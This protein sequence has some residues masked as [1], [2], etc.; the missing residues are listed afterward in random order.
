MVG[1]LTFAQQATNTDPKQSYVTV[2]TPKT[3]ES[4]GFEKYGDTKVNEFTGTTN[5]A[6]PIYTLKS[7]FLET[8]VTLAYNASGIRVNQEASWVG[9]GFDLIAG[10]RITV[11]TRGSVDFCGATYGLSSPTNLAAGMSQI[12][13]H[14]GNSGENAILNPATIV[15]IGP[16]FPDAYNTLAVSDMTQ[17][18]AGEPDIF[19]ANFMGHSTTYYID[20]ITGNLNF[21]GEQSN[22]NINYTLDNN[23]NIISWTIKDDDGITYN[24]NQ[25]ETTTN[26]FSGSPVVPATTT[27]AWLL[28]RAQH[29]NGDYIQYT[30]TNYGYSVPAFN[31]KAS[32]SYEAN[33]GS[34]TLSNDYQQNI[35]LQSPYYLTRME[36]SS[37][38][39]DF[40]LDTRTD[41]Y[42][43]GSRK[44]SQI[45]V[46]DKLT[47]KIKKTAAFNYSY[48]QG[49]VDPNSR[50][51]LNSLSYNFQAYS[52]S[53]SQS[54]YLATSNMRLRL[55]AVNI[56]DN[57]YQPP[58]QFYYYSTTV[59]DKYDMAQDHW[60]YYNGVDNRNN[61]YRF[62]HMIPFTALGIQTAANSNFAYAIGTTN[63]GNSRECSPNLMQVMT[64]NKIV[65]PTGGSSE[66]TYEPHQST[67]IPTTPIQGGGLR[68]TTVKNY[69]DGTLSGTTTYNYLG[70]KYMGTIKYYTTANEL[71]CGSGGGGGGSTA[72]MK[73]SSNGAY[74][75]NDILIGYG[76]ITINQNSPSGQ[77][78]GSLVK[79]FNIAS[80]SSNYSNGL[81]FDLAPPVYG[82]QE[83]LPINNWTYAQLLDPAY[84]QLPPTP[85]TNLE[86]KLMQEKY[87]DNAGTLL[88]SV[89][90]SYQLANYSNK[91]YDIK[92]LQNRNCGFDFG[93]SLS[94]NYGPGMDIRPVN[95]FV[96]PAKSFRTLTQSI[97]E[98][99]YS[100]GNS[101]TN[102]KYFT[103]NALYQM[104]S[105]QEFNADGTS[106]T[107]T[108]QHP[109]D[110]V[111]TG[112]SIIISMMSSHIYSPIISTTITK[113][114]V[115]V[116]VATNNYFN[117]FSGVFVPQNTQIQ[118]GSNSSETRE[119]YNAFDTY[120]HLQER[121][122]VNGVKET[123]LWG[124]DT[125]YPV[126]SIIGADYAT[127]S[128]LVSNTILNAPS[129]DD[130]LRVELN[131]LRTGL[132]G[133]MVTTYTYDNIFGITSQT[134]PAGHISYYNYDALGRLSYIQDQDKN[135][136]KRFVYNYTGQPEGANSVIT[137]TLS[138]VVTNT[139]PWIATITSST[140]TVSSYNIYPGSAPSVLANL[141]MGTYTIVL[142][143]MYPLSGSAQLVFNGVTYT[144]TSFTL[145]NVNITAPLS[146]AIQPAPASGPCSITMASGFSSPSNS[147]SNNGT[148]AS[149]YI[150]FYS[151]STISQGNSVLMGTVNGGC[152]P[153]AMRS[154]SFSSS[155]R[156][157]T[158]TIYP[159]GQMYL[160]LGY[161]S[162]SL[163]PYSTVGSPSMTYNL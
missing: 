39:V 120:G 140:G 35:N 136:L 114:G 110:L 102:R 162:P 133:A 83:P 103:Y 71:T 84:K 53:L 132:P 89:N 149:F 19:R 163:S 32:I 144:G 127:A 36:T 41:L 159:S 13:N 108:Y 33:T 15:E 44:L 95:L 38:A 47:N 142:N 20:K 49:T 118:I 109:R 3:P 72:Q 60:G 4:A 101:L 66:F 105:Q 99:N 135:V 1:S 155:G 25:V 63:L 57:N 70:G 147:I 51:Y 56:N 26:T 150:V 45:T 93:S 62:T 129:S 160:Q 24:F 116:S 21:I 12:F 158:I 157:W 40:I 107:I 31:M 28:T 154:V 90:Y 97:V 69:S 9:L 91:F 50:T 43:P 94:P 74:N 128:G 77:T 8:P 86:G 55:D 29:P 10:G 11:E 6:I 79:L 81:G 134:D 146:F 76:Q 14:L 121:Q 131:K 98:T 130:A 42:G 122:K 126:A 161:G 141:P 59:P 96:S 92:A 137:T 139:V 37:V 82:P 87:L 73:L 2:N 78:N 64:L 22:F 30:Y 68:V 115:P 65:Y 88:K 112:S 17:F 48:F 27:S 143:P 138:A 124:Y 85:C 80:P 106:T 75:D 61:G 111:S 117:P 23:H 54:D 123:Y 100:N 58:Y 152:V 52:S 151:T 153:T 156:N 104:Q 16:T 125:Q 5:I 67:M 18:G 145:P 119:L 113:N 7:R 34:A 148:T 46:T